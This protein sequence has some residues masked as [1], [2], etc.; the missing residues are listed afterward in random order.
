MACLLM[1][2]GVILST[3]V[4]CTAEGREPPFF[5]FALSYACSVVSVLQSSLPT[6][7]S[8][9]QVTPNIKSRSDLVF[10]KVPA[11]RL[12]AKD[13]TTPLSARGGRYKDANGRDEKIIRP[14]FYSALPCFRNPWGERGLTVYS[15][16]LLTISGPP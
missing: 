13:R 5:F 15:Y 14:D 9:F 4:F 8:P 1:V 10:C 2:Y 12:E 6:R 7:P 3:F 16:L 11:F